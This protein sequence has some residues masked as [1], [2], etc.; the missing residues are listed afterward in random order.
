[1]SEINDGFVDNDESTIDA[2]VVAAAL[3]PVDQ[4]DVTEAPTEGTVLVA[5]RRGHKFILPNGLAEGEDLV[6]GTEGVRVPEPLVEALIKAS[7]G[8]LFVVPETK[9][10]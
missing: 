2:D 6:V 1:M 10:D 8:R 9:E 7:N 3:T 4:P 5:T